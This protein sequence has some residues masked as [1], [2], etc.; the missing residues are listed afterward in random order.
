MTKTL[1]AAYQSLTRPSVVGFASL[2]ILVVTLILCLANFNL[3]KYAVIGILVG[4]IFWKVPGWVR[5]ILSIAVLAV[6][7][8]AC[9]LASRAPIP[10]FDWKATYT[11]G[12]ALN[13]T[14]KTWTVSEKL[15]VPVRALRQ[16]T[17]GD[18]KSEK[19]LPPP[20]P[21]QVDLDTNKL[22]KMLESDGWSYVGLEEG[23]DPMF[24]LG[25]RSVAHPVPMV[26]LVTTQTISL[27]YVSPRET[28]YIIPGSGSSVKITG[29]S[30]VI[31]ATTPASE[32][33]AT[34]AGEE[35]IIE[36][37]SF[38]SMDTRSFNVRISTLS[39]LARN[40][41]VRTL[42]GLSLAGWISFAIAGIWT[43]LI[44][45]M[46]SGAKKAG[47]S[48]WQR[49]RR[50]KAPPGTEKPGQKAPNEPD[51]PKSASGPQPG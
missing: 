27:P 14:G 24:S 28:V 16:I 21:N 8:A 18:G 44:N 48:G 38:D 17:E 22:S 5:I 36:A 7:V 23:H 11:V 46:Q 34:T 43:L 45:L 39:I 33:E 4:G 50:S 35:R 42:A 30:A 41:P 37:G 19:S 3:I 47:K 51:Q 26:P 9:G 6:L 29:P 40:E 49:I 2:L 12:V 25:P 10:Q 13:S 20:K 32:A 1:Q 15:I 31:E